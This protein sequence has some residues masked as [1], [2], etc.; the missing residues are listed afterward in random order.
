MFG[1]VTVLD[2]AG[3]EL[4]AIAEGIEEHSHPLVLCLVK[5][6]PLFV[7]APRGSRRR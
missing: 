7:G 5:N 6:R 1:F 2:G 4:D 3:A